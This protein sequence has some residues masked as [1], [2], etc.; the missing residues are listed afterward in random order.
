MQDNE[1][2]N[3]PWKEFLEARKNV[4]LWMSDELG[5]DDKEIAVTLS[6]TETQVYLINSYLHE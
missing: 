3:H 6:M 5:K 1:K 4:I 2:E